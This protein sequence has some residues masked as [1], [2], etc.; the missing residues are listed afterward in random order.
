MNLAGYSY[1]VNVFLL[2]VCELDSVCLLVMNQTSI[3]CSNCI[4]LLSLPQCVSSS[5]TL[6]LPHLQ[7]LPIPPNETSL[8]SLF[9]KLQFY[10]TQSTTLILITLRSNTSEFIE[11]KIKF[12]LQLKTQ[13]KVREN[14][15]LSEFVAGKLLGKTSKKLS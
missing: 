7:I 14:H 15:T 8:L 2:V 4:P 9:H 10:V 13:Q 11:L 3:I 12:Y 6:Q 1:Y 5:S